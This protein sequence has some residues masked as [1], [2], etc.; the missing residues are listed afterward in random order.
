MIVVVNTKN[1]NNGRIIVIELLIKDISLVLANLYAP[2]EDN[3]DFFKELI[4]LLDNFECNNVIIGGDFNLVLNVKADKRG[5]RPTTHEKCRKFVINTMENLD[6]HDVWRRGHPAEFGYTWRSYTR[7]YI[8]CRLDFF[9]ASFNILSICKQNSII[10]PGAAR[11]D[12]QFGIP[13]DL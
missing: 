13:M 10:P 1:N 7:P 6:L 12:Q 2:N 11:C 4:D 3:P 8:Y 9:L 5:G